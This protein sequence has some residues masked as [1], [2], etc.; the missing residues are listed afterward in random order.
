MVMRCILATPRPLDEWKRTSI[1]SLI[2]KSGEK[3]CKLIVDSG[4]CVN[5]V[6]ENAISRMSLTT[7]PHP[8]PYKVAWI[9]KIS[10][11]VTKR[12][13]VPLSFKS[14]VDEVW[15]PSDGRLSCVVRPPLAI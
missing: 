2:F 6:S 11:P 12:C 14:Y 13:L 9:N 15:C 8:T 3:L 4:S 7:E 1:F 10:V 5:V